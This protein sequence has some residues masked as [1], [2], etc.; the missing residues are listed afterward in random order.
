MSFRKKNRSLRSSLR[1]QYRASLDRLEART[2]PTASW[3]NFG[4]NAQHTDVAQGAA[5]PINQ[6]LWE[7]P[8]DMDPW[9]AVH[10][11]D[12]VFTANDVVVVPIKVNWDANDQGATNFF[13]VGI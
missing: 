12:P 9:G 5:Q 1:S 6:L 13:D 2:V 10:Y 8:L 3:N 11:G 4:G 7:G